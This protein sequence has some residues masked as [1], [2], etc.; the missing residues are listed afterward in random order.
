MHCRRHPFTLLEVLIALA[1]TAILLTTLTFFYQEI[2]LLNIEFDKTQKESFQMRFLENRLADI[3]PRAV[4]E[5]TK[6][7]D[8]FFFTVLDFHGMFRG[9]SPSLIF[10]FDNGI[11]LDKEFSNH[12]LARLY[13]D[14]DGCFCL[15][16]WPSPKRWE[17]GILPPMKKQVLMEDVTSLSFSFFI[18]PDFTEKEKP[19]D[20]EEVQAGREKMEPWPKGTW[21]D[22]WYYEYK[23]LPAIIKIEITRTVDK[24]P[25]KYTFAFPLPNASP[26]ITYVK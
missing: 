25:K 3:L 15:A 17:E 1:L 2:S 13:L 22:R 23:Q 18:P 12:V 10:T 8:F 6:K 9:N 19:V 7:K 24:K 21:T 4:P 20:P 11:D 14:Q 26:P 5:K 16:M